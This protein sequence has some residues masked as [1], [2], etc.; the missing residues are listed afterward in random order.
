MLIDCIAIVMI[1]WTDELDEQFMSAIESMGG[2]DAQLSLRKLAKH[3]SLVGLT[4]NQ[5]KS[6][7]YLLR[8]WRRKPTPD[9]DSPRLLLI[10]C[11]TNPYM[12]V[13]QDDHNIFTFV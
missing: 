13:I 4:R 7:L 9:L 3:T 8:K 10:T 12:R 2:L 1:T 6:R 5:I 11:A